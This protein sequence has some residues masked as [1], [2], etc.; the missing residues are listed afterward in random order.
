MVKGGFIMPIKL[1]KLFQKGM[2]IQHDKP[3]YIRGW[4]EPL[5]DLTLF[6]DG[7][8]TE[9][10]A[11]SNGTFEAYLPE[12]PIGGPHNLTI[13]SN[14][15]G[16]YALEDIWIGEVWLCSGQSNMQ[17]LMERQIHPLD[18]ATKFRELA[19]ERVHMYTI[20][21]VP[22]LSGHSQDLVG[23]QWVQ[24]TPEDLGACSALGF[25]TAKQRADAIN[26]KVGIILAAQGGTP[27]EAWLDKASVQA[28]EDIEAQFQ[29]EVKQQQEWQQQCETSMA[30]MDDRKWQPIYLPGFFEYTAIGRL[31]GAVRLR[32]VIAL[33]QEIKAGMDP[34]TPIYLS[35]GTMV[36]ADKTYV[37][38][39]LV[40][41]TGYQYPPRFYDVPYSCLVK[42]R[43]GDTVT[44]DITLQITG[45]RGR[46]TPDKPF[47]LQIGDWKC[48][49]EGE[50]FYQIACQ[51]DEPMLILKPLDRYPASLY[52]SMIAPLQKIQTQGVIWYQGESN[53]ER[54]EGYEDK[55][56]ALVHQYRTMQ[57]NPLLPVYCIQLPEFTIDLEPGDQG[58][59]SIRLA[60]RQAC[61]KAGAKLIT[62]VGLGE[63]N[64]LHPWN[65]DRIAE[66]LVEVIAED[67][68]KQTSSF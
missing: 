56:V 16:T 23:G 67:I 5:D 3:I 46:L 35:L 27:I 48:S 4:C 9:V 45:G 1:M 55:L 2:V 13:E 30:P 22:E 29:K 11:T 53:T 39:I 7:N 40:G 52:N 42:D 36:D 57:E 49:L 59:E 19:D 68:K 44:I 6:F 24:A 66:R 18:Q 34:E 15:S 41:E 21:I 60:Q 33:P 51:M 14:H 17:M 65:K 25:Y 43:V 50:W 61:E 38:G 28:P 12:R 64:E 8:K 10:Q 62:T 63:W 20:P 26:G 54:Y 32:K 37:N 31:S 47:Y 58:W